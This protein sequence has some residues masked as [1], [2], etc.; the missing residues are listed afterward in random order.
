MAVAEARQSA[1]GHVL[2]DTLRIM[3]TA[4]AYV[5]VLIQ[6]KALIK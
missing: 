6:R 5:L 1:D 2:S 4:V 3:L